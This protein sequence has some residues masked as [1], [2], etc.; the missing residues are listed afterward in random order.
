MRI[1]LLPS[2]FGERNSNNQDQRLTTFVVDDLVAIDAGSLA[3][4]C[5]DRQ[6]RDIRNVVISHT[7]LDHI[8]GLPIF[9]DDLFALLEEPVTV[10]AT[11][12]MAN[13]LETHIF[14]WNI[15]PKFSEIKNQFGNVLQYSLYEFGKAFDIEHLRIK[16]VAVNHNSHSSGFLIS[17]KRSTV[18]ITGDT[19][20]TSGIWMELSA[21]KDLKAV[22]IECAFP[23]EMQAL[24]DDSHHLT[25]QT[26]FV[27]LEKLERATRE[28][29]TFFVSNIK[30]TFRKAVAEQLRG[31]KLFNIEIVDVGKVY[32]F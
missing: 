3:F 14:N 17:D 19:A 6:R 4:G 15:Y 24:A 13:S 27:E 23:N 18:C 16:A 32:E 25:P 8:A 21:A 1:Q 7:H 11:S 29:I 22:F 5:N 10:H 12:E 20:E 9:I 30:P 26:L 31:L 28:K 2:S